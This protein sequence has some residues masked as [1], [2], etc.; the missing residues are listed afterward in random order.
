MVR[1]N[2]TDHRHT[3]T[4]QPRPASPPVLQSSLS[5]SLSLRRQVPR[6]LG[7]LLAFSVWCLSRRRHSRALRI[8]I[9]FCSCGWSEQAPPAKP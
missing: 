6:D 1:A 4:H 3:H 2:S 5:L 9:D 8:L 7:C